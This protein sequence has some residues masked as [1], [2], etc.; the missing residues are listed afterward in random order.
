M[1][2][3]YRNVNDA[4]NAL[5]SDIHSGDIGTEVEPSRNG[6]VL[7]IPEP[8]IVTYE[9]PRE[10]VL[11]N[12]ERDCNPFFHLFEA[13]W[14]LAGREDVEPLMR[15][16]SN[17]KDYSDDGISFNGAY[18]YRWRRANES[19]NHPEGGWQGDQLNILIDHLRENPHSR[20]AV[21]QM[22]NVK[23]DLLKI[24]ESA[25]I[26]CN[27]SVMFS[28]DTGTCMTCL[29]TGRVNLDSGGKVLES[30]GFDYS[31]PDCKGL[32]HEVPQYL[33]MT[34]TNRSNDLI[35]GMLGANVVHFSMLQEYVACCLGLEV[36]V[37]NQFTNNLHAYKDKWEPEKWLK[38]SGRIRTMHDPKPIDEIVYN[39]D[40]RFI[41]LVRDKGVFDKEVQ[42][43]VDNKDWSR[44]WQEPFLHKVAHPMCHAFA[45]HKDRNYVSALA[46]MKTVE[47]DD[48]CVAGTNWIQKRREG[49]ECKNA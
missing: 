49:W 27:L 25:D 3:S 38:D 7:V 6:E 45:L 26:C 13:L 19:Q 33:N 30:G 18:G 34:V 1:H 4:F 48:W 37:Y 22:W 43:F 16:N 8:V 20:R 31:C 5:V 24:D 14:M 10:R 42:E 35:W 15:Y 36:G 32:P 23:N 40:M 9:N 28:I 46:V 47:Q 41:N 17:I 12:K 39:R 11:L 44:S 2:G 21:L 29:G